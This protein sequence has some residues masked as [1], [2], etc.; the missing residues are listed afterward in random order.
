MCSSDLVCGARLAVAGVAARGYLRPVAI[1][2]PKSIS[3]SSISQFQSC[4][5]AFRFA[6]IERLPQAPSPAASKGTLVHRALELLMHRDPTDRTVE[7]ALADLADARVE[8]A[9]DPEFAGLELD[10]AAW[11]E[12][13]ADAEALV[14]SLR[15]AAESAAAS[16]WAPQAGSTASAASAASEANWVDG[17]RGRC[18]MPGE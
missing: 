6:Y 14:A 9:D 2:I 3:P 5:L 15:A 16:S 10:D 13:H 8:L 12:F 7:A 4:P 17:P 11:A 1:P 18:R